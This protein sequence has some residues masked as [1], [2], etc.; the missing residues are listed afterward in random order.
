MRSSHPCGNE[1]TVSHAVGPGGLRADQSCQRALWARTDLHQL[2]LDTYAPTLQSARAIRPN[3]DALRLLVDSSW[4][5]LRNIKDNGY[6]HVDRGGCSCAFG[7]GPS[8]K[9]GF[10]RGVCRYVIVSCVKPRPKHAL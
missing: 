8:A 5:R 7:I 2:L 6:C 3:K 9:V 4:D 1:R 10:K